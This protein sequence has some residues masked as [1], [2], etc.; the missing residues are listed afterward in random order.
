MC[1]ININVVRDC[2]YENFFTRKFIIQKFL[3]TKISRSTVSSLSQCIVN[4]LM[5]HYCIL[6]VSSLFWCTSL[7][8]AF[9]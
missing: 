4:Y 3:D 6:R 2:S 7:K 5:C 1:T 8:M 9:V